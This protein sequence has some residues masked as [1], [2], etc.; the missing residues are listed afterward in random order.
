M[1]GVINPGEVVPG[2]LA[3]GVFGSV[4]KVLY[5]IFNWY[6]YVETIPHI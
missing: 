1:K 4:C 2:A 6:K 5:E 3:P